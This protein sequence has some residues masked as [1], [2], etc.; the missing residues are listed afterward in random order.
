MSFLLFMSRLPVARVP[1]AGDLPHWIDQGCSAEVPCSACSTCSALLQKCRPL[2]AVALQG[3]FYS[4]GHRSAE[5][6]SLYSGALLQVTHPVTQPP[7]AL[8]RSWVWEYVTV[9]VEVLLS[10]TPPQMTPFWGCLFLSSHYFLSSDKKRLACH[11]NGER[12][13]LRSYCSYNT[14]QKVRMI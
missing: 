2:Q 7:F 8:C 13:S 4:G 12:K 5:R 9:N 6:C 14:R 3:G 1:A 10:V 11:P